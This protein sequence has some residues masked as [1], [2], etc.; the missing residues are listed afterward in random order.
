METNKWVVVVVM[1]WWSTH[2]VRQRASRLRQPSWRLS[3]RSQSFL[4]FK[5]LLT[6]LSSS[7][8]GFFPSLHYTVA[9]CFS[10]LE[11]PA[12]P[13]TPTRTA[14]LGVGEKGFEGGGLLGSDHLLHVGICRRGARTGA[15]AHSILHNG[16]RSRRGQAWRGRSWAEARAVSFYRDAKGREKK[17]PPGVWRIVQCSVVQCSAVY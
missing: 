1:A 11:C 5:P 17:P 8:E 13:Q 2:S 6:F 3:R 14:V 16:G 7:D 12:A 10:S 4:L 9:L 15:V